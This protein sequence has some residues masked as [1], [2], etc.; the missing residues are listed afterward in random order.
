MAR[1]LA[2]TVGLSREDWLRM[3][4]GGI[5]GS[6]AAAAVGKDRFRSRLALWAEKTGRSEGVPDNERMRLGRDL[7]EYVAERFCEASGKS[8]SDPRAIFMHDEFDCI[9][10]NIDREIIGENAGLECKTANCSYSKLPDKIDDLP[11]Y[12]LAQCYHY[13]NVMKYER[14]YLAVLDLASGELHIFDIP[15]DK[16]KCTELLAAELKFWNHYVA[17]DIRPEPDGSDSSEDALRSLCK[18]VREECR[19]LYKYENTAAELFA[20]RG[21]IHE[22]EGEERKLRQVLISALDGSAIG[23]TEKYR[24]QLSQQRRSAVDSKLLRE[25]YS[26]VYEKCL[27]VSTANVFKITEKE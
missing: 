18:P 25:K 6:D 19:E 7:E 27:K 14:M 12:Y 20:V 17:A 2:S 15:Y 16:R 11:P 26:E 9:I 23:V 5:G 4:L 1:I 8:V 24:V 22:L 10:A 13:L 21:R 3:R